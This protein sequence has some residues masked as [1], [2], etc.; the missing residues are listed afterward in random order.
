MVNSLSIPIN[1][2]HITPCNYN[3]LDESKKAGR[4]CVSKNIAKGLKCYV[5]LIS[6]SMEG[7]GNLMQGI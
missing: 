4:F 7:A 3:C 6:L 2:T 1:P 5:Q